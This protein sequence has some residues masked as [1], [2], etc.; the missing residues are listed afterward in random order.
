M[1]DNTERR[2]EKRLRYNWPV[3]FA[4]DYNDRLTQ[5]QMVDVSSGGAAFTC[6][7][8]SCP[9]TGDHITAR[10]SVP[11]YSAD[12][13]FDLANFMRSGHICRIDELSPFVRRVALQFGEPLPFKPGEIEDTES[14][15]ANVNEELTS[16]E[17]REAAAMAEPLQPYSTTESVGT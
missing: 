10:F 9:M 14:L 1:S 11:H 13:A 7:A 15:A 12:D 4:E 3:W 8:D 5:G 17:E 6:Y 16:I 2:T